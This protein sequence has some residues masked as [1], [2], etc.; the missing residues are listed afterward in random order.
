MTIN[1]YQKATETT[2]IRPQTAVV[3][4]RLMCSICG[5]IEEMEELEEATEVDD[6][7]KEAGDVFYYIASI[8]RETDMD[9]ESLFDRVEERNL[10]DKKFSTSLPLKLLKKTYRDMNGI[11]SD[12]YKSQLWDFLAAV[13]HE[14]V[15]FCFDF[16]EM[17]IEEIMQLNIDKLQDRLKRGV[18]QGDGDRR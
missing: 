18:I 14:V 6:I 13:I 10:I 16:T 7:I 8:A 15:N 4:L 12:D 9:L 5:L 3:N 17:S 11:M 2:E 1:E